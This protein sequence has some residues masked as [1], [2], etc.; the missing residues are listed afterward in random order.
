MQEAAEILFETLKSYNDLNDLIDNGECETQ[1]LEC[2]APSSPK[3]NQNIQI[4]IAKALSGFA[5]TAGG[6]VIYGMSTTKHPHS[7]LDIL[8]QLVPLGNCAVFEKNL[9]NR[10]PTLGMPSI[11]SFKTKTIKEKKGDTKGIVVLY[12]PQ[13]H[14]DPVQ[15]TK[16][17]LF[18]FRTSDEFKPAPFEL[19]K[20]LFAAVQSPNLFLRIAK[21]IVTTKKDGTWHIPLVIENASSVFAENVQMTV[22]I[23]NP[24]ACES[25]TADGLKDMSFLNP[26]ARIFMIDVNRGIHRGNNVMIG[27]IRVRMKKGKRPKRRLDLEFT[28]YA[29]RM[30]AIQY[31]YSLS[32]AQSKFSVKEKGRNY[33]Y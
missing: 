13:S 21:D 29:N 16:D 10:I 11:H 1:Y 31:M 12:I 30:R 2:K 19:I 4:H 20:R 33:L 18:Y 17:N 25:I 15:S 5:N 28:L 24:E 14:G 32:L 7:G 22:E 26:G 27:D 8:T 9:T 6:V 23:S 3:I